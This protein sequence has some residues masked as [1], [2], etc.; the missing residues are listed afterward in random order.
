[1]FRRGVRLGRVLGVEVVLDSSWFIVAVLI[2]WLLG[3]G[4]ATGTPS[5]PGASAVLLGGMA[6][7]LFFASVLAHELAHSVVARRKGVPV[8]RI[9]LFLLGGAAQISTEPRSAGD[10][11]QI[12]L[13]GPALSLVL[14]GLLLGLGLLSDAVGALAG[15]ALFETIGV[16]NLLLAG[17][18]L[19]PGFP[20]DGGRV[21][22]AAVWGATGD[23]R[24]AT[25]VAATCGRVLGLAMIAGGI[26][27]TLSGNSING[28]W[29]LLIGFFLFTSASAAY[30]QVRAPVTP[31]GP[32]GRPGPYLGPSAPSAATWPIV[33]QYMTQ[34]PE[35][36]ASDLAL[37]EGLRARLAASPDRAFP[38]VDASGQIGGLLT[39]EGL[40]AVPAARW[41]GLTAADV[42]VPMRAEM[43]ANPAEPYEWVLARASANPTG[44]FVV[45]DG[46]R[47]VGL[48]R[49]F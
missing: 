5:F 26:L 4:F 7:V 44:R 32:G 22:R 39:L 24:K 12:A 18:N 48:V 15:A 16:I 43:V 19:L 6:A 33:A 37:D 42:M 17:F 46:G 34:R 29:L 10:E 11:V 49:G 23:F 40:E 41:P 27:L 47:L 1:M 28:V 35:W 36:V 30:R 14:G 20:M 25:R 9:T 3:R 2:A 21:L 13:A 31:P 8:H 38:V 45:L